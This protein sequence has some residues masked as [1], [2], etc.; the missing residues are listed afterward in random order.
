MSAWGWRTSWGYVLGVGPLAWLGEVL[1]SLG[2]FTEALALGRQALRLAD[3]EAIPILERGLALCRT[4]SILDWSPTMTSALATAVAREG[5]VDEAI[6]LH[7][8]AEEEEAR[9]MQGTPG[10]RILRFGETYLLAQRI[11]D[12]RA[13]AERALGL[14]RTAGE[15]GAETRALRLLA[16]IEVAGPLSDSGR[17]ERH[18]TEALDR[19]EAH[20]AR[21]DAARC[22]LALGLLHARMGRRQQAEERLQIALAM[23]RGM[24]MRY[25]ADQTAGALREL[26]DTR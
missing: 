22:Q 24:D 11:D 19:S 4:W 23:F 7:Q 18:L 20:G 26:P 25:R 14:S 3:R 21:P 15:D 5:Q 2:E 16:E 12:A 9:Q 1:A 8:R 13:C 17:S 10:G 6:V